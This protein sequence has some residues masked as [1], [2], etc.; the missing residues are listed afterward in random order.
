[1]A[2]NVELDAGSGGATIAADD[3]TSVWYQRIKLVHGADGVNDGDVA[4][5]NPLP[6]RMYI[7][8]TAVTAG[9]GSVAGGTPRVT[10]A[11][12]DPAVASLAILDNA[13]S[14]SEMQVDVVAALPAGTNNIGDVDVLSVIPGTGATNLGKAEDAAHSSG[15]TGVMFLGVRQSSQADFGAD[16]DYVPLSIDDDGGL[17]VSIVAGAGS[18]GTASADDADFSAGTTSGTPAMGVYESSPSSVTDGDMGIVGITQTRALR[19]AVE[20]TVTV[21]SHA[22]TNAG[23]FAVQVTSLPASTNTI[24]VVGDAAHDAAA[25]GNPILMG[26][27]AKAAAPTDVSADADAVRLWALL[28]GS[29]VVNI[30]AGG[31]L[32]TAT[33]SSLNVNVTNTVTVASHAVTNAGTFAVQAAQ[34]GTWT[35]DL[36]ATD[37]A[38]LDAI[39]AS[40]AA[41]D[42]DLTTIIGHVDGLE[43]LIGTTNT[44]TGAATTAL[45]IMD[46][47]DNGASDGASVSG[48]VAHDTADAGEPVKIGAKAETSPKG[49]TLVADGDRTDLYADADG[50]LIVKL[51][52]SGADHV[53]EAVSNTDGNSTAF[54]NFAAVAS[55]KTAITAI[56]VFRTD[57]GTSMAYV[58]FRD[59][60]A[61]SVIYRVPLPPAGGCVISLAGQPIF[62]TSANTALAYDVSSALTTVYISVSGYYTKV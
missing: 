46:D 23:T 59:G 21:A 39:A 1:M 27:Y 28:N 13:I 5:G 25:A 57:S 3:I 18:G 36:G 2:D 41:A 15:D 9:A 4:T 11:S 20:G 44:N 34:S 43:T 42:T 56:T 22:V 24:E 19:T 29:L 50:Q 38:V 45:Q 53:S 8:T 48:D 16:G 32:V 31:T 61:G 55:T 52:T 35:V 58:D 37:N 6:T 40:V 47:W 30:A 51:G 14:G 17:R 10:L 12:D 26:A 60:T 54:T 49:I 7:G 33:S 62:K